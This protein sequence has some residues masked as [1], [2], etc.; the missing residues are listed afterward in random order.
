MSQRVVVTGIGVIT[1]IGTGK[2]DFWKNLLAGKSGISPVGSFDTSVYPTHNGGEIKN[3]QAEE[4]IHKKKIPSLGRASCLAIAA[5]KLALKDAKLDLTEVDREKA[6]VILGTTMGESQILEILNHA[7]VKNGE[8]AIDPRLVPMYP[9]NVL[10]VNVGI[11]FKIRGVNLVIPTA[12]AAGNYAIGYSYD[13]IRNGKAK[14]MLAGGVDAFSRI[15]FTGF[16]RLYSVAPEKCQPFDKNRKGMMVGEGAGILILESLDSALSRKANIYAEVS[17]YG[18]SCD[19]FHMTAPEANGIAMAIEKAIRDAGI[20][21]ED[22]DYVSAHG[23]ATP[24][25]DKT[26]CAALRKV[27]GDRIKDVPVSSIKSMLGHT[28]GAASGIEAITCCLVIR[29]GM[30]PPTINYQTPDPE[31]EIDCV[32]NISRKKKVSVVLNNSSAF[33][34][35]NACVVVKSF[36][37]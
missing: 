7:W 34:G 23:T 25:N 8:Q 37:A 17:G 2:D 14:V 26:E 12:C 28:M 10:S 29:D 20:K 11:A 5:S 18:L 27:F 1:S 35:N 13:L 15:A 3:F 24:A 22:V 32:P 6:G 36:R 16:N 9:A 21:K 4:F 19:A 31:C 30:I 33:G